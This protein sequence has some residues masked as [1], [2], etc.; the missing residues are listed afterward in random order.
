MLPQFPIFKAIE[1]EDKEEIEKIT[2]KYPPYSDFNFASMWSWDIRGEMRVSKLYDNLVIRFTDYITDKLFYS[3]LGDNR[4]TETA[5]ELLKISKNENLKLELRLIPEI[6]LKNI[7]LGKF[8]IKE[9]RDNFD[10]I[11]STKKLAILP[12]AEYSNMRRLV[13]NFGK[14]NKNISIRTLDLSLVEDRLEILKLDYLWKKNKNQDFDTENEYEA[15]NRLLSSANYFSLRNIGVFVENKLIAF[16]INENNSNQHA[17][18]FFAKF[19]VHYKGSY[20]YSMKRT[21]ESLL[22]GNYEYLNCEQ[23]LGLPGLRFCK[24][25]L[26]PVEYLKKFTLKAKSPHLGLDY[27]N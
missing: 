22:E 1:L 8:I 25:S 18:S 5:E 13:N 14:K 9:D 12:G 6:S 27:Q 20:F 19:D 3:F 10:Y 7:D 21:A 2:Q 11:Y 16:T 15:L 17:T 26:R 23:D 24:E 4:T